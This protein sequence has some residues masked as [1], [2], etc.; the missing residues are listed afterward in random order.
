MHR[1]RIFAS[2]HYSALLLA[3]TFIAGS[4]S[5]VQMEGHIIKQGEPA[6]LVAEQ[7]HYDD[8]NAV[9]TAAGN[10]EIVQGENI[11]RADRVVYDLNSDV[12]KAT[13]H[14]SILQPSGDVFFADNAVLTRKMQQGV[15]NNFKARLKDN[16][17][18][19]ARQGNK[20]SK[21][22]TKLDTLAFSPCKVCKPGPGEKAKAPLWQMR[23]RKATIDDE[24][25]RVSYRDAFFDVYGIP[26]MYT[27]Y[28]SHATPDAP[29]Q[30]GLLMPQYFHASDLGSVVKMPVYLS[31][32]P[33]MDMTLTPWYLSGEKPLLA[34]EFRKLFERGSL[35]INGAFTDTYNRDTSGNVIPGTQSRGYIEAHGNYRLS[36]VWTAGLDAERTTDNTFLQL[37]RFGWKDTLTSRLY[38]ERIEDR[39]Y[40]SVETISF[41]GLTTLDNS[42]VSPTI[43]PKATFHYETAP[44]QWHS[45]ALL[46]SSLLVSQR[47]EGVSTRRVSST[48]SWKIPY[49]TRGGQVFEASASLRGDV[50]DVNDQIT[51]PILQSSYSGTLGRIVPQIDLNWRYPFINSLG[52]GRSL[53]VAPVAEMTLSPRRHLSSKFPNEDSQ[54]AEL[55]DVNLFTPNRF[56]GIDQVETG[57]R[58]T[59]GTRGHFQNAD[60]QWMEWL[61]GQT[62]QEDNDSPF[63][64]T[65]ASNPHFSDYIGR[66]AMKYKWVEAA[67]SFRLD[68]NSFIPI[69]NNINTQLQLSPVNME[70]N[71]VS[72]R[73]DP[74]FGNREEIYGS[75]SWDLTPSWRW[76]VS[77]RR[78][79]GSNDQAIVSP[80]FPTSRLSSFETTPG[81]VGLGSSIMFHN[82]C[83]TVTASVGRSYIN[84]QDVRPSTTFGLMI[85]LNKL[86]EDR[87]AA[88]APAVTGAGNIRSVGMADSIDSG[89]ATDTSGQETGAM[90]Q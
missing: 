76:S 81:A 44:M 52:E 70:V 78:D 25:K 85:T 73:D 67:Y 61:L 60:D 74:V 36:D 55:S 22:V 63:P 38:A 37:Y 56:A 72:L 2:R 89:L 75:A 80:T 82:E 23:A 10:V 8:K 51:D 7:V 5:A 12:V 83:L 66:V 39:N 9:A 54:V 40:A 57:A 3:T 19:V 11:L 71:Y 90:S 48:G 43:L 34:G 32:A 53:M 86:T 79:L 18:F 16:A 49:I 13:G 1:T 62:Y 21:S 87:P 17:L 31:L 14:V 77:G 64:I 41:Q 84:Q 4:A 59:Y 26:V 58:F 65:S 20:V 35:K 42:S 88:R 27:P 33:D 69:S 45:R 30:S 68:R 6:L 28:F 50:Y 47:N 29:S 46:D 15:V 24:A